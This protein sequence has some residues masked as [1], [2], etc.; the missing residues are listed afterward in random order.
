MPACFFLTVFSL[1]FLRLD[2]AGLPPAYSPTSGA[3][4]APPSNFSRP[5]AE[6][7]SAGEDKILLIWENAAENICSEWHSLGAPHDALRQNW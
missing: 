3:R 4:R 6:E 5:E 1:M 7:P 2:F